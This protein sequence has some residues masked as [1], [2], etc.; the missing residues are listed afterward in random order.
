MRMRAFKPEYDVVLGGSDLDRFIDE[1]V[2]GAAAAEA[3]EAI[4]HSP[5]VFP[6]TTGTNV[7]QVVTFL[8][9]QSGSQRGLPLVQCLAFIDETARHLEEL[10]IAFEVIGHTTPD[11]KGGKTYKAWKEAGSPY[12]EAKSFW[13][14]NEV[15][16]MVHKAVGE[17]WVR[18]GR[19][20]L[21]DT[22]LRQQRVHHENIDQVALERAAD[23]LEGMSAGD[24]IIVMIGDLYP[25]DEATKRVSEGDMTSDLARAIEDTQ[26]R[27]IR[28]FGAMIAQQTDPAAVEERGQTLKIPVLSLPEVIPCNGSQQEGYTEEMRGFV[29]GTFSETVLGTALSLDP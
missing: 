1:L 21:V 8:V 27:G 9:D 3:I 16:V 26:K 5:P 23:R 17:S 11:W 29:R 13:R 22:G 6:S 10:G 4:E 12:P 24:R 28:V 2:R 25:L 20:R 15:L 19:E 7:S 18:T 14:L